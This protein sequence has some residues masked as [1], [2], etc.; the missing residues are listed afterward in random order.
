MYFADQLLNICHSHIRPRT[1]KR[2]LRETLPYRIEQLNVVLLNVIDEEFEYSR[3]HYWK[4]SSAYAAKPFEAR[5]KYQRT[6][7][8][9]LFPVQYLSLSPPL[10]GRNQ[11]TWYC[12]GVHPPLIDNRV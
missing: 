9:Q 4:P 3:L 5:Q 10:H 8:E 1:R 11:I 2:N 6:L 12:S 7:S